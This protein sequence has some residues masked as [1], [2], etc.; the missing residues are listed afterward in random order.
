MLLDELAERHGGHVALCDAHEKLTYL[1]LAQRANRYAHWAVAQGLGTGDVV[2]LLMRNCPD[3]AA[4][5]LGL[6]RV[7]CVVALLNTNLAEN[8]LLHCIAAA[9]SNHIIVEDR[10]A[11]SIAEIMASLPETTRCWTQ[12]ETVLKHF[13]RIDL[14]PA[15]FSALPLML[16]GVRKPR[17][18][19]RALLIYTSG[20]TGLPKAA[21]VTHGRIMEWSYWFTAMMDVRP[22]D[23][24][25]DCLPMYHSTGGVVAIGA[26]LV[27]G[28]SVFIRERF[29]ARNFWNDIVE[30][31]CTIF[32]YI[33]ELCRYLLQTASHPQETKHRLRLCCGNGLQ[34]DVWETF[35][36][37][38][39]IPRILEFYAA[40]E[41]SVTLYN[42]DGKP[43]AIGRVP[44]FLAHRFPM[45][46][47]RHDTET[48]EVLRD[49]NGFCSACAPDEPGEAIGAVLSPENATTKPFY[50]Y[51]DAA[52]SERKLLR[53]AFSQ[54][55]CWFRTGD[56]MRKDA[57]GYYYF[58]DRIGDTF[59]WKGENVSA[60][61]VAS[62]VM[63][64]P[65]VRQAVVFGVT[66][67]GF[68]G[69][70]GMAAITTDAQFSPEKLP[71][72][73]A[74]HL[75]EYARPLFVRVCQSL[76]ITGTFKLKKDKLATEGYA[77]APPSDIVWFYDRHTGTLMECDADFRKRILAG[78][79]RRL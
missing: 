9:A 48:G 70:A 32:Q 55:D 67:P 76:E 1:D 13:Q 60:T 77:H 5:W 51:T 42:Y 65:G 39:R 59:R 28:G 11:Q 61:E 33:G 25:Y 21:N 8:A 12:G 45:A 31:D 57:A 53:H 74:A 63:A 38:Y 71:L 72:H 27:G 14:N 69:R 29:S 78:D 4:L 24:L 37:R 36:H 17:S 35:Q 58:V 68:D 44:P 75:P 10:L 52:A 15:A 49:E 2:C 47:V 7:G 30:Q 16:E 18:Q 26:M 50:G 6:T 34:R 62:V 23:R 79:I 3:Y 73:L 54:G 22:E 43:G 41:G 46:L 20:T 40:T 66:I 64:C 19:D 56:L